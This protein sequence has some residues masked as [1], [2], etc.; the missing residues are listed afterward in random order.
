VRFRLSGPLSR[1]Q[2][3]G[4][5]AAPYTGLSFKGDCSE[6]LG[7]NGATHGMESQ[8]E[9]PLV[10]SKHPKQRQA[11]SIVLCENE[12][13]RCVA[14]ELKCKRGRRLAWK[15]AKYQELKSAFLRLERAGDRN[16]S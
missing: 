11:D 9:Q 8:P 3:F 12:F 1:N 7:V 6:Q 14:S 2:H 15:P 16:F 13:Y 4:R 5:S 10:M